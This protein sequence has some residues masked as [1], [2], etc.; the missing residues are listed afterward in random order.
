M[1]V[2]IYIHECILYIHECIF[3]I[4][5]YMNVYY[6]YMADGFGFALGVSCV[7]FG[8]SVFQ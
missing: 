8:C 3:Y 4:Y 6:I 1:Y 5:I 7:V 2:Y